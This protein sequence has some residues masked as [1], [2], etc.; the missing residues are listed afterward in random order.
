MVIA[1]MFLLHFIADFLLQ[2][3][4]MGQKKS[5]DPKFLYKHLA[6]Q[7]AVFFIGLQ[8]VSGFVPVLLF[9]T[10]NAAIHGLIDWH[11]WR[12][13]KYTVKGWLENNPDHPDTITYKTTGVWRYWDDHV[14]YT[15][16]G[17]DQML[18]AFTLL[19]AAYWVG[20]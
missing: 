13:Y 15:T 18:H 19:G 17:L 14:F 16:I 8:V 6:I 20:L 11:I 9:T 4:E 1:Y 2:S 10:L 5:S 7:W 12:G 3:R